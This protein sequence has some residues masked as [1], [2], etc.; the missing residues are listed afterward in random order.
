MRDGRVWLVLDL[1]TPMF[2]PK[3]VVYLSSSIA[4]SERWFLRRADFCCSTFSIG[5]K[6]R[7]NPAMQVAATRRAFT[8]SSD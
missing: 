8:F 3:R 4:H 1:C 7:P 6:S 5:A 2:I